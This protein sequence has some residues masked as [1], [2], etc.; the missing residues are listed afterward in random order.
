LDLGYSAAAVGRA[1][2]AGRLHRLD[3]GVYAVG[4][5]AVSRHGRCLAAVLAAGRGAVLSHQS[6][7]WLWGLLTRF[8]G[9]PAV[10]LP[11]RGH[12]KGSVRIHHSTILEAS[13]A[14]VCDEIPATAVPRTLLDLAATATERSLAGAVER[15][16]RL[17]LLD[18]DSIDDLLG[19]C[20][21]HRGRRSLSLA[22]DIYRDPAFSRA[23]SERLFL[24]LIKEAGL[25]RPDLN[26]FVAGHEIDA[27][28]ERERFAVEVD[29]WGPHRTRAA[30]ERDPLR[31][32]ELKLAGIDSIRITARRIETEPQAV[33]GR[34]AILLEQRRR[35]LDS[36]PSAELRS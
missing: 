15:A 6:A 26:T 2:A 32:E 21:R 19:R 16:E 7:G 14:A 28:W 18:L 36:K 17:E 27:Y 8:P 4:H 13:D 24:A 33:A 1:V 11:R 29:G 10:T 34:L 12:Q 5:A 20:G 31:Q 3:R 35:Y 22:L 25:P 9:R 30:F 23:R